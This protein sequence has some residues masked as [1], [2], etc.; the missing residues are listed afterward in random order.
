MI[1][2]NGG[3]TSRIRCME[4]KM[5]SIVT[6]MTL[7]LSLLVVNTGLSAPVIVTGDS[8]GSWTDGFGDDTGIEDCE[9]VTVENGNAKLTYYSPF[10]GTNWTKHG[11]VLDNGGLYDLYYAGNSQVLKEEGIYKMWYFGNNGTN[12]RILYATS[13]DGINWIKSSYNPVIDI[14]QPG[15]DDDVHAA[16]PVVI[17]DAGTYKMWYSGHDGSVYRIMYA[18]SLDGINW[19]KYGTVLTGQGVSPGTVIIEGGMYKMWYHDLAGGNWR[20]YYANSTDGTNWTKKGM[21][22]DIGTGSDLDN[23]HVTSATVI[24]ENDNLYRMWY[25]GHDGVV[26]YRIFYAISDNE[27]NWIKQ[28]LAIDMGNPGDRDSNTVAS[29]GLLK[30]DDGFYKMWH[31]GRDA[32]GDIRVFY[33][34]T[35]YPV[36]S[37]F[38]RSTK[39]SLPWEQTWNM[40]TI[41]KEEPGIDNYLNITLLNGETNATI[42]GF[43]NLTGA[44]INISSL[45]YLL[46]P[47]IRLYATFIGNGSATPV[48]LEWSVSWHDTIP[49]NTPTGLTINNPFTGYSLILSWDSNSEPDLDYYVIYISTDNVSFN[50]LTNIS[51]GTITFTDYGLT[52]GTTYYYQ[53]I[54][55]AFPIF[56]T[57]IPSTPSMT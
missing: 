24:K 8:S 21:V 5:P 10:N 37:G 20:V 9:N 42:P 48:L 27:T 34:T 16:N 11:V 6:V 3:V 13:N 35:P 54:M 32:S 19:T 56:R 41:E 45:D 1:A 30:D 31:S 50:W 43:E 44:I 26:G 38:I 53:M 23:T 55:M 47:S 51:A 46:Y 49:P 14:G 40:L 2:R 52:Q 22:L 25:S 29:T 33:A 28:G 57:S 39:I 4:F 17:K 18:T 15:D 12:A 36:N 7:L